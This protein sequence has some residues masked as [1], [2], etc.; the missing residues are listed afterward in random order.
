MG[1]EERAF[2]QTNQI[3]NEIICRCQDMI[4]DGR[5]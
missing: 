2:V 5:V 4:D 1:L 3:L